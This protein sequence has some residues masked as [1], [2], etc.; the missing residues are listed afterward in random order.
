MQKLSFEFRSLWLSDQGLLQ[1][2]HLGR[3]LK[4]SYRF[5]SS[6]ARP[7][8][9]EPIC[10]FNTFPQGIFIPT[11][12]QKRALR[13]D[14]AVKRN[15]FVKLLYHFNYYILIHS[16]SIC[17]TEGTKPNKTG[18]GL[19][20]SGTSMYTCYFCDR[21]TNWVCL[22]RN[23]NICWLREGLVAFLGCQWGFPGSGVHP[24]AAWPVW[25][26]LSH[27]L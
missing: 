10:I 4:G 23:R 2:H 9:L 7:G 18:V 20:F 11:E 8:N 26:W 14:L 27:H 17:W 15:V 21:E 6:P 16:A 1:L 19:S 22:K 13:G 5:C 24:Q 3:L 25:G 12:S